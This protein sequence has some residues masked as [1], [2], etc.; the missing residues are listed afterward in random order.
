MMIY[1]VRRGLP[2]VRDKR[3]LNVMTAKTYSVCVDL[4]TWARAS[5]SPRIG[6]GGGPL[7]QDETNDKA[8]Q[9]AK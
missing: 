7:H 6:L 3:R 1:L 5:R 4:W 8:K 9:T 2:K